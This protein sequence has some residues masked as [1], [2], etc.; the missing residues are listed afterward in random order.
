MNIYNKYNIYYVVKCGDFCCNR[1]YF[2][3]KY[4]NFNLVFFQ[5]IL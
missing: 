4:S 5:L 2:V 3:V 1:G